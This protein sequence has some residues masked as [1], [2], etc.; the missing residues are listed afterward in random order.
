[1]VRNVLDDMLRNDL[2]S[3]GSQ[4]VQALIVHLQPG[5]SLE[6]AEANKE[7]VNNTR[8]ILITTSLLSKKNYLLGYYLRVRACDVCFF[9]FTRNRGFD[10][11]GS[12][13][14]LFWIPTQEKNAN[15]NLSLNATLVT[16]G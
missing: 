4:Q 5:L 16:L 3:L 2:T 13:E 1:M 8:S 14:K 15:R 10:A 11:K 9:Y 7:A 12:L 6:P